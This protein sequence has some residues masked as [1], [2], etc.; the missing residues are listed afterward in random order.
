MKHKERAKGKS[1]DAVIKKLDPW[2][3]ALAGKLR[4]IIKKTLPTAEETIKW[5][6]I[7]Y[8]LNGKNLAWLLFYRDHVDFGFFMGAKLRSK[9]L[10]G[11]GKGLRHIKVRT[12]ADI[13]VPEFRRLLKEAAKLIS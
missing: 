2:K 5:G 9:L 13:K 12:T 1:I 11:T 3:K 8:L 10:E 4:A 7:T 6:N